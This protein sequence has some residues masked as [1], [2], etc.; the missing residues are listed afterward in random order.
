MTSNKAI[1]RHADKALK[2]L[3]RYLEAA[4][5]RLASTAS[6]DELNVIGAVKQVYNESEK[7]AFDEYLTVAEKAY[8]DAGKEVLALLPNSKDR[9][10]GIT[11]MF[12]MALLLGYDPKTQYV[13]K[14]EVE[15][16]EARLSESL[17]AVNQHADMF[18]SQETRTALLRAIRLY[19]RQMRNMADT[20]TDEARIQAF[21]DAGVEKV[22]WITQRDRKVCRICRE[23]DGQQYSIRSVPEKHPNCRCFLIPVIPSRD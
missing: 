12:I 1:Y 2:R 10:K 6:W 4:L 9:L 15:R 16:K 7:R 21:D 20:V 22:T 17:I 14:H 13:Y 19:E 3:Y 8:A 5:Q 18:N 11:A 23:R